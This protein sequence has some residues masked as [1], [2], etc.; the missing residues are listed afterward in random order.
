MRRRGAQGPPPA[1]ERC[2]PRRRAEA[3]RYSGARL[4]RFLL[5]RLRRIIVFMTIAFL[6]T[7]SEN[8]QDIF[9]GAEEFWACQDSIHHMRFFVCK[10]RCFAEESPHE[11]ERGRSHAPN[12]QRRT[13]SPFPSPAPTKIRPSSPWPRGSS[14]TGRSSSVRPRTRGPPR[15]P[16]P[17]LAAARSSHPLI[18]RPAL[19]PRPAAVFFLVFYF[20]PLYD[21]LNWQPF[22]NPV[23]NHLNAACTGLLFWGS[24]LL[25]AKA[26][27]PRPTPPAERC[28]PRRTTARRRG[29]AG[30]GGA[31]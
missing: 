18:P 16:P 12:S 19:R 7:I 21:Q 9:A 6:L 30:G 28:L 2:A 1:P 5:L 10:A 4:T 20:V 31:R 3:E 14:W 26:R 29:A 23:A 13:S 22:L 17:A 15:R 25:V 27:R 24:L 11:R 8:T